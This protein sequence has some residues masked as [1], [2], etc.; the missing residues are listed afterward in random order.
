MRRMDIVICRIGQDWVWRNG[1]EIAGEGSPLEQ[2]VLGVELGG[3]V[4]AVAVEEGVGLESEHKE[5]EGGAARESLADGALYYI[6]TPLHLQ[7]TL[8]TT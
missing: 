3:P 7:Q 1:R 8:K 2:V 4:D 5:P 6:S